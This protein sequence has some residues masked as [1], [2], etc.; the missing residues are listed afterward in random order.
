MKHNCLLHSWQHLALIVLAECLQHTLPASSHHPGQV[1]SPGWTRVLA[2]FGR[3][4]SL[5]TLNGVVGLGRLAG[6]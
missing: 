1:S 5:T 2:R 6:H 3:T 4:A